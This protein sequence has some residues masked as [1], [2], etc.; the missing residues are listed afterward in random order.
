MHA[1]KYDLKYAIRDQRG[2]LIGVTVDYGTELASHIVTYFSLL[3]V[4][5]FDLSNQ[6]DKVYVIVPVFVIFYSYISIRRLPR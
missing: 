2:K 3:E 6:A 1:L 4:N 5:F